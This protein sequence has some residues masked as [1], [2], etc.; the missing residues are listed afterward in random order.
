[1]SDRKATLTYRL[2]ECRGRDLPDGA[3]GDRATQ[4][5]CKQGDE[6]KKILMSVGMVLFLVAP[7]LAQ[8]HTQADPVKVVTP[9]KLSCSSVTLGSV[10]ASELTGNTTAPT[11]V[12]IFEIDVM[13][14]SQ[15]ATVY[16]SQSASVSASGNKIGVPVYPFVSNAAVAQQPGFVTFVIAPTQKW[17]AI[18]G[19]ANTSI[20][21]CLKQ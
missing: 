15:S 6:M 2:R 3:P 4:G 14:L 16:L 5:I 13:P 17:Y 11:T 19:A 9:Y 8:I 12:P 20:I 10:T 7:A 21:V 18:A 1:M